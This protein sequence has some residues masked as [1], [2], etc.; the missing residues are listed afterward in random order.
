MGT[1]FI[2]PSVVLVVLGCAAWAI[3]G[4]GGSGTSTGVGTLQV[5]LVDA[6]MQADEINVSISS[7]QVH[8]E[9]DGWVTLKTYEPSLTANL[10]DFRTGGSKLLL[11]EEPLQAGRYTMV[12]LMLSSAQIVI[13]GQTYDVDLTNVAQTGVKCNGPFTVSDGE[14]VALVLDFN[15]AKSFVNNPPGSPNYKLHPVMTMSPVNI[16]TEV[17][18]RIE[19]Q[20]ADGNV[21]PL[22]EEWSVEV[23]AAGHVGEPDYLIASA[24]ELDEGAFRIAVLAGGTYDFRYIA[25]EL[26]KDVTGVQITPPQADLGTIVLV[27]S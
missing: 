4:C 10:L 26:S 3:A 24:E 25:G 22:P 18:G 19:L 17:I 21:L 20:D 9:K 1:G 5:S 14:L 8:S 6:P 15:A 7:I 13:G 16:A 2:R 23:Y 27:A 11:A 12:R